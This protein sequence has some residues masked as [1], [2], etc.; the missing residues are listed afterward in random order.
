MK[1]QTRRS[2][3]LVA[4]AS[5][6]RQRFGWVVRGERRGPNPLC[7]VDLGDDQDAAVVPTLGALVENWVLVI[8]RRPTISFARVAVASRKKCHELIVGVS[9]RVCLPQK[10][11]YY[12]EHGPAQVG[13]VTGCG[14]D[15]AHVHV[16]PLAFDLINAA[17]GCGS[18]IRWRKADVVDPWRD[19]AGDRD[20]YVISN[21]SEAY[22]GE[23][24]EKQ[25]QFFRRVIARAIGRPDEWDF[26]P[27]P[28]YENVAVTISNLQPSQSS[29]LGIGKRAA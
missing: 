7:D 1:G 19:L 24:E 5:L 12:F 22:V 9:E 11:V 3:A 6:D 26:R 20:Y 4:A 23:P 29:D 16:V 28:F 14:V 13:T 2:E 15:Q 18:K 21:F 27:N 10:H 17:T 8:P 25:S